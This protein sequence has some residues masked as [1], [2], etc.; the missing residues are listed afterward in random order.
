MPFLNPMTMPVRNFQILESAFDLNSPDD[1]VPWSRAPHVDGAV[2]RRAYLDL[3]ENGWLRHFGPIDADGVPTDV[4]LTADGRELVRLARVSRSNRGLRGRTLR[5]QMLTWFDALDTNRPA[6]LRAF[7]QTHRGIFYGE[8]YTV[9]ETQ[10]AAQLLEQ[11]GYLTRADRLVV[12]YT[13]S[14]KGQ[15][16]MAETDGDIAAY[17]ASQRATGNQSILQISAA[18]INGSTI[19]QLAGNTVGGDLNIRNTPTTGIDPAAITEWIEG[20]TALLPALQ[21][22]AASTE[23]VLTAIDE[24]RTHNATDQPEPG[25]LRKFGQHVMQALSSEIASAALA[26]APQ[27]VAGTLAAG[28][29]LFG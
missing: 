16:V 27:L 18:T 11:G 23:R 2:R 13:I 29:L 3:T 10:A 7:L 15:L 21:M 20:L 6:T 26:A 25:L 8:R 14:P 5:T 4:Q 9:P 1:I 17:E 28:Q 12:A 19:S 24:L 22:P